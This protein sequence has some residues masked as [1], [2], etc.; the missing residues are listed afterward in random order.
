MY[1]KRVDRGF[2]EL[3]KELPATVIF[4]SLIYYR[5]DYFHKASFA[6]R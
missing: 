3:W 6:L 5:M 1:K 4:S 2:Y